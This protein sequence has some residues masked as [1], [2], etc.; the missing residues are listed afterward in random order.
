VKAFLTLAM[1]GS[2]LTM[3]QPLTYHVTQGCQQA[4][5]YVVD[6]RF[7]QADS[8]LK[9]E[10]KTGNVIP[11]FI[12][13]KMYFLQAFISEER[14]D[15]DRFIKFRNRLL[16]RLQKETP[17]ASPY[18]LM[19]KSETAFC[20]AAL[21]FKNN[22]LLT[23]A[24]EFRKAYRMIQ[25]NKRRY[26]HF[27]E[28]NKVAGVMHV[29]IGAVPSQY[30]WLVSLLGFSGTIQQGMQELESLYELTLT[31]ASLS[32]LQDE[33][34]FIIAF[35]KWHLQNQ[36]EQAAAMA[37]VMTRSSSPILHFGAASIYLYNGDNDKIIALLDGRTYPPDIHPLIYLDYLLGTALL[38]KGD[39]RADIYFKNYI[40]QFRGTSFVRSAIQ[41]TGWIAFLQGDTATYLKAMQQII[42]VHG[43]FTDEDKQALQE[44][45]SRLL[46]HADLLRA[47]LFFDGGYYHQSLKTLATLK[48]DQ[49]TTLRDQIEY[50]Y[51]LARVY[52]KFNDREKAIRYYLETIRIGRDKSWYFA[53]N[54]ALMLGQLYER[55]KDF[56]RAAHY[57]RQC[58]DMRNHDYENSLEQK[59]RAGLNRIAR[60]D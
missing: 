31:N 26:R 11:L 16:D 37:D 33:M 57:F 17:A 14:S 30:R 53:A 45:R 15:Y 50:I 34:I 8:L 4:Y 60:N 21:K 6:L 27:A 43:D 5:R 55:E 25:E 54:S 47:R 13:T 22:E 42:Q 35:L 19:I 28:N 56:N 7:P 38:N 23:A 9:E 36:K 40:S 46:P 44:A 52:D 29:L 49:L 24:Y 41:K 12:R 58:I 48:T 59:A 2:G 32:H 10:E 1:L 51:R 20:N 39:Y 3:G 18:F